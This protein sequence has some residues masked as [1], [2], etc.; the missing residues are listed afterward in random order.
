VG[1]AIDVALA[2]AG[3]LLVLAVLDAAVRTFVLPRGSQVVLTALVF[4]PVR[5]V[6][7]AIARTR[8]D[9][10]GRDRVMAGYAPVTLL[11]LPGVWLAGV[12]VGFAAVFHSLEHESWSRAFVTSGSSLLTLGFERPQGGP[13]VA[14]ALIEALLGLA[15]V[16]LLIAY[17]PT[18]Y[19]AFSRREQ[20]V[21]RLSVRAGTP[22]TAAELLE[23]AQRAGFL[24]RLDGLFEEWE[25][26][27]VE[28]GETHTS[29]PVLTF[30]RSPHAHR[31]WVTASGA[32]LDAAALRLAVLDVPWTPSAGLCIRSGFVALREVA[33]FFG[34]SYDPDPRPDDPISI[35]RSEFDD[36]WDRLA[37]AGV[38]LVA[39]RDAAWR[40]FAGWRV[41]YDTVLLTLA[42]LVMAPYAPWSSDRS[43]P[44][45]MR[46]RA[47]QR[48]PSG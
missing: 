42:G 29:L 37:A 6:F 8:G 45:S 39:D 7:D 17:L 21:A 11:L 13:A 48:R 40:D 46:V 38:P 1:T 22:P 43:S 5:H 30:F 44:W 36:A 27:F 3:G 15:L 19:N 47:R 12:F 9:W 35:A 4:R 10:E 26:W 34:V 31:S 14:I 32:M 28:L 18:I 25:A 24:D 23:R 2:V 20:A 16:A 33:D 41:N